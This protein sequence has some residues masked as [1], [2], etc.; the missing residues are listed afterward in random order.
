MSALDELNEEHMLHLFYFNIE[1]TD[2]GTDYCP[3][4]YPRTHVIIQREV[5][6]SRKSKKDRQLNNQKKWIKRQTTIYKTL[7]I[8]LRNE[9][10]KPDY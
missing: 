9:Q 10:N 3:S 8:K 6:R 7:H 4:K 1:D 2:E 5:I